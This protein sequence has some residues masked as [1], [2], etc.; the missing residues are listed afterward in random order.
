MKKIVLIAVVGKSPAVVTEAIYA[1]I[2]NGVVTKSGQIDIQLIT[3]GKCEK[4]IKDD[5]N[6]ANTLETWINKLYVQSFGK[7]GENKPVEFIENENF[8]ILTR[9][10]TD[11]Q[12][13]KIDD[14][15][16]IESNLILIDKCCELA[17]KYSTGTDRQDVPVYYLIAGGR[18]TMATSIMC[19]AQIYARTIDRVF[20]VLANPSDVEDCIDFWYP[21]SRDSYKSID[22]KTIYDRSEIEIT[23]I[24]QPFI[25]LRIFYESKIK[26]ITKNLQKN[27]L[28]IISSFSTDENSRLK[29]TCAKKSENRGEK[30]LRRKKITYSENSTAELNLPDS[31]FILYLYLALRKLDREICSSA[32]CYGCVEKK[33]FIDLDTMNIEKVFGLKYIDIYQIIK[34]GYIDNNVITGSGSTPQEPYISHINNGDKSGKKDYYG[35]IN[36]FGNV[37]SDQIKISWFKNNENEKKVYGINIDKSR[38]DIDVHGIFPEK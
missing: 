17:R 12:P 30:D 27:Y 3:T 25:P 16:D 26:N 22:G 8:H 11:N 13:E 33:C 36:T 2:N 37:I 24:N 29:I 35:I 21:S 19:A 18:K 4:R 23:L 34:N 9:K 5:Q 6:P 31:T 32:T 28:D 1:L 20:H 38:I 14:L 15:V 10:G 7:N